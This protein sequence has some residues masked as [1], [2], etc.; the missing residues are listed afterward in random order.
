[1][2]DQREG[3]GLNR[4]LENGLGEKERKDNKREGDGPF[5]LERIRV[6]KNEIR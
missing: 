3:T 6:L 2:M 4:V 5:N 1:M